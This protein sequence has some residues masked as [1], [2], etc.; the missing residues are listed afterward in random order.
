MDIREILLDGFKNGKLNF[1]SESE[2]LRS[3][4][5]SKT[6]KAPL[7][8]A[9]RR[10]LKENVIISSS[11]KYATPE[12]LGAFY[13]TVKA[14]AQG[15][16]FLIPD[17]FA[18]REND[19]FVPAKYREGA[20]NKDRVYAY[21]LARGD[22]DE[23]RIIKIVSRGEKSVV[24]KIYR[25][26]RGYYL[27]PDVGFGCDVCIRDLN[28]GDEGD[29]AK[30]VITG[31]GAGIAYGNVEKVLGRCGDYKCE[32]EAIIEAAE[33]RT[34]F[35]PY[36]LEAAKKVAEEPILPKGRK[37]LRGILTFTIDG[38]DTRDID[39]AVSLEK[40]DGIYTLGVH[41][42]DVSRYVKYNGCIDREAYERGTSVYFPDRVLPMLPQ[43]L[44]N[45]ACSL[46]E[47][48]DRYAL[49]CIMTF[50]EGGKRTGAEI[51]ESIIRSDRRLTYSWVNAA[52]CGESNKL[53]DIAPTLFE[54]A[55]LARVLKGRRLAAGE[56]D[57]DVKEA[58]IY[59]D[60]SGK[61]VIPDCVRGES[62]QII[63]QFMIAANEAVA[64][65]LSER[66]ATA[67]Y[68]VHEKP[69]AEKASALYTFAANLGVKQSFDPENATPRD[70][71][72]L[73]KACADQ[74]YLQ[75]VNAVMLRSM[76]K[77]R[78]SPENLGHFGLASKC[79]CHFTSPIRRYPDLYVHRALKRILHGG[80]EEQYY[81]NFAAD[82]AAA[83]TSEKER[84]AEQAE[85]DVDDV[86]KLAYLK[87]RVGEEFDA[88][89]SGVTENGLYAQLENTVEGHIS[90]NNMPHDDYVYYPAL[91]MLAGKKHR[92]KLGDKVKIMVKEC[93]EGRRKAEFGLVGA[94]SAGRYNETDSL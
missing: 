60:E 46:N 88:T 7:K 62:E 53:C 75:T 73:L 84:I 78:Y 59:L 90:Y 27:Y 86:Y 50:D 80:T 64:S 81:N 70:Y 21:P 22:G 6:Y 58:H 41:I 82:K 91:F 83:D 72:K 63:E 39:D 35:P 42:A 26:D 8:S 71:Q 68:R 24:G 28:G 33:L 65:F 67:L 14:S 10:L 19:Y 15:Y 55:E 66:N 37:D 3:L 61:I 18:E 79:Y 47:G 49:S 76:Q 45:G 51:C 32:E 34:E 43:A 4:R 1:K 25:G 36:V 13:A 74:P 17:G 29:K 12:R 54:M 20:L 87:E 40:K 89:I 94:K 2:I 30:V 52:L 56:V 38:D 9:L 92:F 77:A 31:Y 48:E 5:L 11:G 44:S 16:L 85:R 69:A 23:A 93:E 57:L